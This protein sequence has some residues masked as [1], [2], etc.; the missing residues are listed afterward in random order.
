MARAVVPSIAAGFSGVPLIE[1]DNTNGWTCAFHVIFLGVGV[2]GGFDQTQITVH[3]ADTD[4]PAAM[5]TKIRDAVRA[6]AV[7]LGITGG[8]T[9]TV[10]TFVDPSKL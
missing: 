8:A 2:L 9:I 1:D 6:E 5:S 4:I 7:R 10:T 3:F